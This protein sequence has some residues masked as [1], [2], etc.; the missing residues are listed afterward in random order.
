MLCA[1]LDEATPTENWILCQGSGGGDHLVA[2]LSE[3]AKE[4][5]APRSFETGRKNCI[6]AVRYNA[7]RNHTHCDFDPALL[8]PRDAARDQNQNLKSGR[9]L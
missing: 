6:A 8:P 7:A 4:Q 2:N 5:R 1:K 3:K 9:N